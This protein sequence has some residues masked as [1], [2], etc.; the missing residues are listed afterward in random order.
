MTTITH[1]G[2]TPTAEKLASMFTANTGR[3]MLDSG[4]AYG[5][6]FERHA[7]KTVADFLN[8]PDQG[9][10]EYGNPWLDAFHY[11][12][13]SLR[14]APTLDASYADFDGRYPNA[15]YS[16]TLEAWLETLGVDVENRETYGG[17][18]G[19]N[20]YESEYDLLTQTLA[21]TFF[22]LN[23]T[24]YVALQVHGGCDVRGGY[25]QPAIFEGDFETL[26]SAD[27]AYFTCLSSDHRFTVDFYEGRVQETDLSPSEPTSDMLVPVTVETEIPAGWELQHGCP[28][29]KAQLV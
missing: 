7:G 24:S 19:Y 26:L 11:L 23:D 16:E 5:R 20:T 17:V 13:Q 9:I 3:H 25:T 2:V 15:P 10:S 1:I 27:R 28:A 12:N 8:A 14:Y 6:N 4:N 29:C 18:W 21:Y 22:E